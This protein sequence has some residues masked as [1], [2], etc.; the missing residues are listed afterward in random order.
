MINLVLKN[1]ERVLPVF[2]DSLFLGVEISEKLAE[3]D[4]SVLEKLL[5]EF[6]CDMNSHRASYFVE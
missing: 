2:V 5:C 4:F 6:S 3:V 1:K